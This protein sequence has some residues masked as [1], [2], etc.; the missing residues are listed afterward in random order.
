MK[1]LDILY[2]DKELLIVNKPAKLLTIANEKKESN[3]FYSM[4]SFYVKKQ[5]PKNK[6]FIVNRLDRDTSGIVVFA[7]NEKLKHFLQDH[8]QECA[9]KR[10]YIGVVEGRVKDKKA[11]LKY[12]LTEDKRLNVHVTNK[13]LGKLC[14]TKFKVINQTRVYTLLDI[15]ILSGRKH[16]IRVSLSEYGY[17]LIGDKKYG[18]SKNPIGRL[19][20]HCYH[21]SLHVPYRK[22]NV[23]IETKI[24]KEFLKIFE[25]GE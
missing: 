20:L 24:P 17:P 16:Q 14:T 18:A 9:T 11:T 8:W 3:T 22:D 21:L 2:E 12:Y 19:G 5:Y 15:E 1:K 23:E 25:S 7:K 6:V 4:A 13:E 10:Q